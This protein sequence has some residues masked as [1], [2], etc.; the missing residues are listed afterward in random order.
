V[1]CADE[2][3]LHPDPYDT[4]DAWC[5]ARVNDTEHRLAQLDPRLDLPGLRERQ[6]VM[7]VSLAFWRERQ[8][9]MQVSLAFWQT[10]WPV[11]TAL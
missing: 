11:Q 1:A 9:V 10:I 2:V 7:R 3:R 4:L 5:E 6:R 8:R